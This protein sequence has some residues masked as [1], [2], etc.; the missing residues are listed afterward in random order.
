MSDGALGACETG[1]WRDFYM[2]HFMELVRGQYMMFL[3]GI[4]GLSTRI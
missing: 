3:E 1:C 2:Q 4:R